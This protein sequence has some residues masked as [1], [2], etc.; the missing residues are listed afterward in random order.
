MTSCEPHARI[1]PRRRHADH[2]PDKMN[3]VKS[4]MRRCQ[5]TLILATGRP[6]DLLTVRHDFCRWWPRN[7][8]ASSRARKRM[9]P[10][11]AGEPLDL[12]TN[13]LH[14]VAD[15]RGRQ[16]DE[17]CVWAGAPTLTGSA[18]DAHTLVSYEAG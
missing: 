13:G 1:G 16:D 4:L 7:C 3:E 11:N 17:S 18:A 14:K 2:I 9:T 5:G 15:R 6:V 12:L 10:R 8:P